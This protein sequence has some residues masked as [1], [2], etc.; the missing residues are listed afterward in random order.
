VRGET[1]HEAC[2]RLRKAMLEDFKA[3]FELIE[4]VLHD[5]R[6]IEINYG[7]AHKP[8][9]AKLKTNR[10]RQRER[11]RES[12]RE[13]ET[14]RETERERLIQNQFEQTEIEETETEKGKKLQDKK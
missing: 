6:G 13:T 12:E 9:S 11:E 7:G 10:E 2:H 14:E 4:V 8:I 1:N 5:C 3:P